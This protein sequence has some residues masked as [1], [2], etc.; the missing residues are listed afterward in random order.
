MFLSILSASYWYADVAIAVILA[1]FLLAGAFRGLAKSTKGFFVFVFIVCFAL[2]L[3]GLTHNAVLNTSMGTS[4]NE[5]ISSASADWGVAFNNP[6][7]FDAAGDPYI[8]VDGQNTKLG[9]SELGVKGGLAGFFAKQFVTEEGQSVAQFAA[10]GVTSLC[11]FLIMF[12]IYIVAFVFIFALLRL[13]LKPVEDTDV[14][15]LKALDRGLG[16]LF[17]LLVGLV[18]IWIVFSIFASVGDKAQSLNDAL[19]NSA[20]GGLLYNNNPVYTI[21]HKIF[22]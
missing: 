1:L 7:Y 12:V 19:S 2:L 10:N 18:C 11:V 13:F 16:A 9:A 17:S 6:V 8:V 5:K 21:F 14:T 15:W 22:G 4:I 3:T 20:L